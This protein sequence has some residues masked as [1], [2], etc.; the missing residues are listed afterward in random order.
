MR[1]L[2]RITL[3]PGV[4]GGKSC[5]PGVRVTAGTVAG[6]VAPGCATEDIL[7]LYPCLEKENICE[8]LAYAEARSMP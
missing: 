3:D 8:A 2:T 4:M 1:E 5:V 7:A 6:L